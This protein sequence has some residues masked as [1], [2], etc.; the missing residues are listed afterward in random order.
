MF[1]GEDGVEKMGNE[2][3]EVDEVEGAKEVGV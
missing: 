1:L 3:M 2:C